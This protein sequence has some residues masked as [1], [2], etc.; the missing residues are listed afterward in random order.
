VPQV[1]SADIDDTLVRVVMR[2]NTAVSTANQPFIRLSQQTLFL[3][4]QAN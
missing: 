4:L 1:S 2:D 3:L